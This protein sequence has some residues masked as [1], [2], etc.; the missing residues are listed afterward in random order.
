MGALVV[1]SA[2]SNFL[3]KNV[4]FTT[5]LSPSRPPGRRPAGARPTADQAGR[6]DTCPMLADP[7]DHLKPQG[8]MRVRWP[9]AE[10]P[11]QNLES[12]QN[13]VREIPRRAPALQPT[14]RRRDPPPSH[15]ARTVPRHGCSKPRVQSRDQTRRK[16][17]ISPLTVLLVVGNAKP[18]ASGRVS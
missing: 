18:Q 2:F 3:T 15:Q 14:S 6:V 10:K 1:K 7:N 16:Q 4:G 9:P 13:F 5:F 12:S 8:S 11:M 17:E